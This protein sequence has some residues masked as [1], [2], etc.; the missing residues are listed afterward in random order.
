M[1]LKDKL[2][3]ILI[4]CDRKTS[5]KETLNEILDESSPVKDFSITILNNNS[6]DGTTELLEDYAKKYPEISSCGA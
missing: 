5:L 4:T 6:T 3:I 2:E 1:T